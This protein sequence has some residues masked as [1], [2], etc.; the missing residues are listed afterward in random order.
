MSGSVVEIPANY[1]RA[2]LQ[3]SPR[4]VL[5]PVSS[6]PSSRTSLEA[7]SP[8]TQRCVL[9]CT[10]S[11]CLAG[12]SIGLTLS[13]MCRSSFE[14]STAA[15][16]AG[17]RA[18]AAA[19]QLGIGLTRASL[20]PYA[21]PAPNS[22]SAPQWSA[23]PCPEDISYDSEEDVFSCRDA[24][25]RSQRSSQ[26]STRETSQD[27][28]LTA[29]SAS[30]QD[31]PRVWDQRN[32]EPG[33]APASTGVGASLAEPILRSFSCASA[34]ALAPLPEDPQVPPRGLCMPVQS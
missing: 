33:C 3:T 11:G 4:C 18:E 19:A 25:G 17:A 20:K 21:L 29:L 5:D 14:S 16:T 1:I 23:Q 28:L 2:L 13:L 10:S 22:G 32:S 8:C 34:G 27:N 31:T 6:A 15:S 24:P 9:V 30:T 12:I 26:E 7:C